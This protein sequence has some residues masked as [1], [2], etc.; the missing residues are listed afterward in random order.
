[1]SEAESVSYICTAATLDYSLLVNDKGAAVVVHSEPA[2]LPAQLE[3]LQ[4]IL[5]AQI[6][7]ASAPESSTI[8]EQPLKNQLTQMI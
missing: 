6:T 8:T 2:H 7:M 4:T 3:P 5:E 1:M